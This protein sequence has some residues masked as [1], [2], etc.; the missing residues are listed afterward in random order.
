MLLLEKLEFSIDFLLLQEKL[1]NPVGGESA[2]TS[3]KIEPE[4]EPRTIGLVENLISRVNNPNQQD[5]KEENDTTQE[6]FGGKLL[7]ILDPSGR[8]DGA[9][10]G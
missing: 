3:C 6:N 8:S 5:V 10:T 1:G 2:G 9:V 4:E 7:Q